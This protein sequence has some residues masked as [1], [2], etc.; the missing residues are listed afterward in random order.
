MSTMAGLSSEL[1]RR[2]DRAGPR[3]TSYPTAPQFT[4]SFGEAEYRRHAAHSNALGR[5]LSLYVH[6]PYCFSPCFYCGCNRIITRD[7][8]RGAEYLEL[9]Q[10][11]IDL[12]APLFDRGR[13]VVQLH[14]GG[15]TP[16]FLSTQELGALLESLARSFD[17]SSAPER[18]FSI[19]ID[20]RF[21]TE[22]SM[23][24]LAGL[25]FNRASLGVQDFDAEVQRAINRQQSISETLAVIEAG[26]RSGFRSI[27]VD[28]IYG[29]PKQAPEGFARTLETVVAAR[30]DRIAIYGY[31]HLP[32]LFKAQRRIS[33]ADLP[34]PEGRVELLRLAIERLADAGY[35]YIGMDHFAL[36]QDDL[37][38]AQR[39]AGLHRN[40]MGYTTHAECDLV[41]LGMSAISHV[42]G[43]FS[44]N[45]RDLRAWAAA[46]EG[47]RL[48]VWRGLELTPDDELRGY[49]IQQIMCRG[50]IDI[51]AV[52]SKFDVDFASYFAEA[53]EKLGPLAQD[54]LVVVGPE[55]ITASS[56]GRLVLR[57]IAMCFDGYLNR[58]PVAGAAARFSKVL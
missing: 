36:P 40:F 5:P 52:E 56:S 42:D 41:A 57:N 11:E 47:R 50:E 39:A 17:L 30:P 21:V 35:A 8:A 3:Y 7:T 29:L 33:S 6:V 27:N 37:A 23:A 25:G 28:L 19:E 10:R 24:S 9:L 34:A 31:A 12:T 4:Q 58:E 53:L 14:L 26:R 55:R 13:E 45:F 48:P 49:V 54:A 22:D 2:H 51:G 38:R 32:E 46:L 20:P 18:D 15:G 1:L 16:N 44:Q 43:C